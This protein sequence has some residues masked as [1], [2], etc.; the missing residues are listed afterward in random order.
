MTKRRRRPYWVILLVLLG[1]LF[2]LTDTVAH[3]HAAEAVDASTTSLVL[4]DDDPRPHVGQTFE[5]AVRLNPRWLS[6]DKASVDWHFALIDTKSGR[7]LGNCIALVPH[8]LNFVCSEMQA[9]KLIAELTELNK[10]RNE[11]RSQT[12]SS[13]SARDLGFARI[14]FSIEQQGEEGCCGARAYFLA[15]LLDWN[16]EVPQGQH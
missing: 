2:R 10:Q 12:R 7:R 5:F 16:L 4:L 13:T 15:R 9:Q 3:G 14:R 1:S 8:H 6:A 11:T